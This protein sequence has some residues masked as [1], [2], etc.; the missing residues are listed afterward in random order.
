MKRAATEEPEDA[1]FIPKRRAF[2]PEEAR[3]AVGDVEYEAVGDPRELEWSKENVTVTSYLAMNLYMQPKNVYAVALYWVSHYVNYS[4]RSELA[5]FTDHI[6]RLL[7]HPATLALT[8][9][10][11]LSHHH[12]RHLKHTVLLRFAGSEM[13]AVPNEYFLV[14]Q[15]QLLTECL[16]HLVQQE[17]HAFMVRRHHGLK[18]ELELDCFAYDRVLNYFYEPGFFILSSYVVYVQHLFHQS[19]GRDMTDFA[20]VLAR[21]A[22]PLRALPPEPGCL[23][24]ANSNY[25]TKRAA[26]FRDL[27]ALH[28]ILDQVQAPDELE[29]QLE[30]LW[31][32]K[33]SQCDSTQGERF[34][35][36]HRQL[37]TK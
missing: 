35:H 34:L 17:N 11:S 3:E 32:E 10:S 21:I 25:A 33:A 6:E 27:G 31:C 9:S 36:I 28:D 29:R 37:Y 14:Q 12:A 19:G 4:K 15:N 26:L 22:A 5:W 16:L 7:R 20:P 30:R 23:C 24:K 13:H 2:A 8:S 1:L 18:A